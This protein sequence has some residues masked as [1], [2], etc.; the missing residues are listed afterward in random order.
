MRLFSLLSIL[1]FFKGFCAFRLRRG[2]EG[3]ATGFLLIMDLLPGASSPA[4]SHRCLA[5]VTLLF[6][7]PLFAQGDA[8][9]TMNAA[10]GWWIVA[11]GVVLNF[12]IGV[13]W[14]VGQG[15]PNP[16]LHRQFS[17]IGHGHDNLVTRPELK[18]E[19]DVVR[20]E[21]SD[22]LREGASRDAKTDE[23]LDNISSKISL[24]FGNVHG[25]ID[26]LA[27]SIA[28]TSACLKMHLDD[29]RDDKNKREG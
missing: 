5:A 25:R 19:L 17:A 23:K 12:A 4:W 28:V 8:P 14:L 21:I 1:S 16:A 2:D 11:A 15:K 26:P 27:E 10:I 6:S 24:G 22:R 13:V 20:N 7:F 18:N 9:G 3:S 29:H